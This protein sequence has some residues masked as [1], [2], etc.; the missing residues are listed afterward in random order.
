[1]EEFPPTS[2]EPKRQVDK[3]NRFAQLT[4]E[5]PYTLQWAPISF[6]IALLMGNLDPHLIH[7]SLGPPE[8]LTQ[9]PS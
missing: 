9:T 4:V 3:F 6:T 1:M 2:P 7:G 8:S 5:C